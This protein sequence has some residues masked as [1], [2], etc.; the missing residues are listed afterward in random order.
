M[1]YF[2]YAMLWMTLVRPITLLIMFFGDISLPDLAVP[3][4]LPF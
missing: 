3:R 1:V 2:F 4:N